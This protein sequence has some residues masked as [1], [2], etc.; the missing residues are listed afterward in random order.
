V[1]PAPYRQAAD[2][3]MAFFAG[4]GLSLAGKR[5]AD[6]GC[7]DGMTDLVLAA[8]AG[9][10]LV[11]GFDLSP[12]DPEKLAEQAR[13]AGVA[14]TY[15]DNLEFRQCEP[16]RLNADDASFDYVFSWSAFEHVANPLPVLREIR[17]VLEPRGTLMIQVWPFFYSK[18]GSHLWD[19]Y[20]DGF[21]SL[22]HDTDTV[23]GRVRDHPELGP[24]WSELLLDAFRDLNRITVD[25]LHRYL[26]I[27]GFRIGKL[28][29]L[30][31][32]LHIPP[33]LESLPPSLVGVSGVKLLACRR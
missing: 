25:E 5:V 19:W 14:A 6:I 26:M 22:L 23:V 4:D 30:T 9:P 24:P 16:E 12:V 2:E 15:P 28:Q 33:E 10:E 27:A 3:V 20:P 8:E 1:E 11:V 18:H 13:A 7:G 29:L 21:A 32:T 17:R 31:E